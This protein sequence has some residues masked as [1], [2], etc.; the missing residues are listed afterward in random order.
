MVYRAFERHPQCCNIQSLMEK[1]LTV[2]GLLLGIVGAFVNDRASI[3]LDISDG[4][5]HVAISDDQ[6]RRWVRWAKWGWPLIIAGGLCGV[7]AVIAQQ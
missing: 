7:A 3:R 5:A 2:V 6:A 1:I 4:T